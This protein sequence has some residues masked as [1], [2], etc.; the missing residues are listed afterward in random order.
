MQTRREFLK[1]SA[2]SL[3]V[4]GAL[5]LKQPGAASAQGNRN[6]TKHRRLIY[7]NDGGDLYSPQAT[8][9]EGFLGIL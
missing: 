2:T 4:V 7:N 1:R 3:G 8:T 5:D 6:V 9:P